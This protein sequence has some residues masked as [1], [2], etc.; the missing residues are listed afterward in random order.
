M[1]ETLQASE[2]EQKTHELCQAIVNLPNFPTIKQ[3]IDAFMADELLKFKFQMV[4]ERSNLLQM[5][6]QSG[7]EITNEEIAA[8]EVLRD[9]FLANEVAKNFLEAQ[10]QMSKMQDQILR[11]FSKTFE[12]GRAAT[13]EDAYE[14]TCCDSDCGYS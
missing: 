7:G 3:R 10:Q 12:L 11:F 9:E 4:N 2:V 14:G 5:K 8:F 13:T 1:T 6:Q